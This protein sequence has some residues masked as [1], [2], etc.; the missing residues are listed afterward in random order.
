MIAGGAFIVIDHRVHILDLDRARLARALAELTAYA[1]DV[2]IG[3]DGR[4]LI[5]RHTTDP[6]AGAE[7]DKADEVL[8]AGGS[9][10]AATDAEEIINYGDSVD[11]L[12][13]AAGAGGDA[14]TESYTA[15]G[16]ELIASAYSCG[17][18]TVLN[19]LVYVFF[20]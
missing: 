8:R 18:V 6:M 16:A 7:G 5:D 14:T 20:L 9:T 15:V 11:D 10:N 3:A 13:R 12:Y 19:T 4:A 17:G 2:A 1:S